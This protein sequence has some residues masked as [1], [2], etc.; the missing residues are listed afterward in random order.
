[1][2]ATN[3]LFDVGGYKLAGEISGEGPLTVVFISGS[4]GAGEPWDAAISALRSSAGLLT[5]ARAGIGESEAPDDP[6]PRSVGAAAEELRK[7]LAATDLVRPLVLVG[8]PLGALIALVF[9]AQW[10]HDLA[11]LVLVDATDIYL[12]L[13]IESPRGRRPRSAATDLRKLAR[14]RL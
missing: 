6:T 7:L 13:D 4:G 9:A 10:P 12:N 14:G 1:M 5:Y 11:G 8:H 2:A 3:S